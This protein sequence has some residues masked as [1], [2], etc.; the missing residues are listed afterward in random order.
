MPIIHR[1]TVIILVLLSAGCARTY[2]ARYVETSHF[3]DDY[4]LLKDGED[5]D[6]LLS[7]WK[8]GTNWAAYKKIILEP[9]I[10]SKLPDSDLNEM[11]HAENH[12]LTELFEY[13][14]REALKK[15]FTLVAH[16]GPNTLRVQFAITDAES[17]ILL[18][19]FYTAVYPSARALSL[20]KRLATG[21]ESFV[22][23][24]SVEGKII[25]SQTGELL[26]ASADCRAGGKTIMGAFDSLD[27]VEQA[28][29]YWASQLNYQLCRKQGHTDCPEPE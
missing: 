8:E 18:L 22:G 24:A 9:V 14:M 26:M 17:S 27:D 7:F 5:G 20:L 2:Q 25:D 1:I 4:S 29:Q 3:L 19:D 11:T 23:K 16:P 13:R 6:A 12:R 28:Y 15:N 10:T 21:T